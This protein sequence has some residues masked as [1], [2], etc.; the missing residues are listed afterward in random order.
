M[1]L[2]ALKRDTRTL[3]YCPIGLN[4]VDDC[5]ADAPIGPIDAIL[6]LKDG[7]NWLPT[8]RRPVITPSGILAWPGLGRTRDVSVPAREYRV[9]L[10]AERYLPDY[11]A[12]SDGLLFSVPPYNDDHPPDPL[13]TTTTDVFLLPQPPYAYPSHVPVIHGIVRDKDNLP[14]AHALVREGNRERTL[15]NGAGGFS[16]PL[17]WVGAGTPTAI[18]ATDRLGWM[19][20]IEITLP[21]ALAGSQNITLT[22]PSG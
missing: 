13:T 1:T 2:P 11:L 14:V 10:Q 4:L 19:G 22:D 5:T 15:S 20:T 9:R 7:D 12:E 18:D 3:L 16:L 17:R 6:E 21:A 8:G